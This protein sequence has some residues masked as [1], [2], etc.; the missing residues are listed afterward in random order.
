MN[1]DDKQLQLVK[2]SLSAAVSSLNL[3]LELLGGSRGLFGSSSRRDRF[4]E[5]RDDRPLVTGT[6]DGTTAVCSDGNTYSVAPSY[7]SKVA[8]VFGDTLKVDRIDNSGKAY[9]MQ[10]KRV[11]RK[12]EEGVLAKKDGKW[13]A[14]T[15]LGSYKLLPE[16]VERWQ[17]VEGDEI[18]VLIPEENLQA[19]FAAVEEIKGRHVVE[20]RRSFEQSPKE[21]VI[22]KV[23]EK[24]PEEKKEEN[25][26]AVEKPKEKKPAPKKE[27]K[28]EKKEPAEKAE[29]K[30]PR[31]V[32]ED[33]LR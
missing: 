23:A 16:A 28:D 2:S 26:V 11:K 32:E 18:A 24:K 31:V 20:E 10:Y 5:K 22:T 4:E 7:A 33:D 21:P 6:F 9:F 29:V 19:P 30:A 25:P 17:A 13:V 27:E 14:V 8:L 15:S 12:K 1:I 3:A